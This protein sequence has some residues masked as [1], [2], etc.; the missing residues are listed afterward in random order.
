LFRIVHVQSRAFEEMMLEIECIRYLVNY[1]DNDRLDV[2]RD[3]CHDGPI[4][5]CSK[6]TFGTAWENIEVYPQNAG[7]E[8][9]RNVSGRDFISVDRPAH[10]PCPSFVSAKTLSSAIASGSAL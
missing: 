7:T 1:T 2:H 9:D 8:F 6:S 10:E 5:L 3:P 4:S